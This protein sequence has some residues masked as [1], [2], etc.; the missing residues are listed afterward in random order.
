LIVPT[1]VQGVALH[2]WHQVQRMLIESFTIEYG[3]KQDNMT[4]YGEPGYMPKV[5][6]VLDLNIVYDE[7]P[8]KRC[9]RYYT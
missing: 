9:Y 6:I 8:V 2:G 7:F 1:T 5:G 3:V 4:V